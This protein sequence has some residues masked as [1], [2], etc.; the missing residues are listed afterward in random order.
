MRKALEDEE[1]YLSEDAKT[2]LDLSGKLEKALLQ[3]HLPY[4]I[5]RRM[6]AH[7]IKFEYDISATDWQDMKDEIATAWERAQFQNWAAGTGIGLW[8]GLREML[9]QIGEKW[10]TMRGQATFGPEF[11]EGVFFDMMAVCE[12][13]LRPNMV[14]NNEDI[15]QEAPADLRV[16]IRHPEPALSPD[17]NLAFH[18]SRLLFLLYFA[19]GTAN[20]IEG[21]TKLVKMDFLI[22]YPT[23]LVEAT[24]I[25][26]Q[27]RRGQKTWKPITPDIQPVARPESRMIRFKY[28]PWDPRYYDVFAYLVAKDF[29]EIRPGKKQAD[30]FR[31]TD[32][33]K[34]AVQE[35]EGSEFEEIIKRCKL[36]YR[37]FGRSAGTTIKQFIY[38]YF[39]N[40]MNKPLGAELTAKDVG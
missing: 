22:R 28:G 18:A 30:S 6:D 8:T 15:W 9:K 23:Y 36:V 2:L 27:Q 10:V 29:I 7:Q 19:G 13:E 34:E 5:K 1:L 25:M 16:N 31:L 39:T 12:A 24:R 21:R 32:K 14:S 11:T 3:R 26:N 33:G 37:L 4:A 35:L 20:E 40:L 17:D 38:N